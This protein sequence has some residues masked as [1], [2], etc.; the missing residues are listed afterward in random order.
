MPLLYNLP[1]RWS[2]LDDELAFGHLLFKLQI[3]V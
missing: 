3:Q 2:L 1:D